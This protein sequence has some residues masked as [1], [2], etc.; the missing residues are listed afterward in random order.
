MKCM[1]RL[2]IGFC[3]KSI[4]SFYNSLNEVLLL[5]LRSLSLLFSA[6]VFSFCVLL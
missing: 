1:L 6:F 4:N 2:S 3:N 5:V